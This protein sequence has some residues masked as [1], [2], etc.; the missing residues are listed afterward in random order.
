LRLILFTRFAENGELRGG[1]MDDGWTDSDEP[2]VDSVDVV[3]I[4]VSLERAGRTS[5]SS[6]MERFRFLDVG[7]VMVVLILAS[8]AAFAC[9]FPVVGDEEVLFWFV[10]SLLD[11]DE[12]VVERVWRDGG[13]RSGVIWISCLRAL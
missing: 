12:V 2:L 10:V 3:D 9:R 1:V 7:A 8:A 5:I 6:A 11:D 4:D 13:D